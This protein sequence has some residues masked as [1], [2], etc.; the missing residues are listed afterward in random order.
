MIKLSNLAKHQANNS[1]L[2][3]G[4]VA[5]QGSPENVM[6][7]VMLDELITMDIVFIVVPRM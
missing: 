6:R 7:V 3:P 2:V 1:N 5:F 4:Y